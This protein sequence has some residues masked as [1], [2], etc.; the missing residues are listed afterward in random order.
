MKKD[1]DVIAWPRS[2][3]PFVRLGDVVRIRNGRDYKHLESGPVPVYGSGGIMTRVNTAAY[4]KPSV[5]IPRKGS[6]G[7]IFYVEEPFW[8][9]DTI[10]FTE[11]DQ[12]RL[13]PKFLYYF[14]LT[15]RLEERNQAGGV[16]SQTQGVLNELR[17][18]VPDIPVQLEA[19]RVLD[20]FSQLEAELE[21]ELRAELDG[22]RRQYAHYRDALLTFPDERRERERESGG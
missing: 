2:G 17:V 20:R 18:P 11:I 9:V 15:L 16:P 21:A 12:V 3:V 13:V 8:T 6:L 22:R 19:V 10:F 14:L 1:G 5:L 7:N 4:D